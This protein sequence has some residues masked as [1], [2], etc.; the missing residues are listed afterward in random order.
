MLVYP[1]CANTHTDLDLLPS[2]KRVNYDKEGE[3]LRKQLKLKIKAVYDCGWRDRAKVVRSRLDRDQTAAK[4]TATMRAN[5]E[6]TLLTRLARLW[7]TGKGAQQTGKVKKIA[8]LA[9]QIPYKTSDMAIE[10]RRRAFI[11]DF[12]TD[13]FKSKDKLYNTILKTLTRIKKSFLNGDLDYLLDPKLT[14]RKK[15][16]ALRSKTTKIGARGRKPTEENDKVEKELMVWLE[17]L[18][19]DERRVSRTMVIRKA[20]EINPEFKGGKN[21]NQ[22]LSKA[23]NWFYF[24]FTKKN[25]LSIRK[26][27]SVGQ[28]LPPDYK[29][30]EKAMVGKVAAKQKAVLRPDGTVIITGVKDDHWVNTD[31][32]PTWMEAKGNYSWGKKSSERRN[33]KTG[34]KEKIF[35]LHSSVSPSAA[36]N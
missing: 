15:M 6:A 11:N 1:T 3:H 24:T 34:G 4:R 17:Q 29:E 27:C 5:S 21:S 16:K 14:G 31:H 22:F 36:R 18:W 19:K 35:S 13:K 30:K 2:T 28:K 10:V 25:D 32:V 23:K 12:F 8:A 33:A 26:L 9:F 20:L 7:N